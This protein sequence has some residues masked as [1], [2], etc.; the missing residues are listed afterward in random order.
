MTAPSIAGL[1]VHQVARAG[2]ARTF[3]DTHIFSNMTVAENIM[4]GRHMHM[5]TTVPEIAERSLEMLQHHSVSG[6]PRP[7]RTAGDV[8][9]ILELAA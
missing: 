6:N 7:V 8:I 5:R 4:V 3:Q 2:V 9:E 1:G